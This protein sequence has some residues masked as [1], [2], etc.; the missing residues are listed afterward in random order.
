[1]LPQS[2]RQPEARPGGVVVHH[3]RVVV[4]PSVRGATQPLLPLLRGKRPAEDAVWRLGL[5]G[6]HPEV[7]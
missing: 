4:L 6:S 1:M 2:C 5:P 7:F 3:H